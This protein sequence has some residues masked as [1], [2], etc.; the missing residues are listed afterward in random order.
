VVK[1]IPQALLYIETE[2]FDK[3]YE[4]KVKKLVKD[5]RLENNIIFSKKQPH[6]I[7]LRHIK[8]AH[9]V[10]VAEQWENMAPTTLADAMSLGRPVVASRI[11]G[12]PEMVKDGES[13]FLAEPK[14]PKDFAEKIIKILTDSALASRIGQQAV[15]DIQRIGSEKNIKSQLLKLYF[16][17]W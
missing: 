2:A 13:G 4:D 12:I 9:L 16:A 6:E 7:Y 5:L 1:K 3:V 8:K 15:K 10:V 14:N 11:G 17:T